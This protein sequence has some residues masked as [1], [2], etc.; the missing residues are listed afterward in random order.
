MG[1]NTV[2]YSGRAFA[3]DAHSAMRGT[4]VRGLIELITNCDDAYRDL[5]GKIRIEV[6]HRRRSVWTVVV[7]DR[8]T[9]MSASKLRTAI[10]GLGGRTSGFEAGEAVR[11]NLGRGAKD[12]A[13]FGPVRFES[14]CDGRYASMVLE[15]DGTYDDPIERK[16]L[17]SDRESLGIPKG[18]GTVVTVQVREQVQ[19]PRHGNLLSS[20]A[21]HYQLRDINA[22]PRR[23]LTL[24]DPTKNRA[25]TIRYSPPTLAVVLSVELAIEGYPEAAT[26]LT[27]YR[28]SECYEHAPSDTGRPQGILVKGERAIYENSLFRFENQP[29]SGWFSG[30]LDCPYID[31]LARDHDQRQQEGRELEARNPNPIITRG[32]DGLEPAHPFRRAVSKAVEQVLGPLIE[33]EERKAQHGEAKVSSKLRRSLDLLGQDLGKLIDGDLREIDEDGIPGDRDLG[34][35]F[36]LRI[37]PASVVMYMGESKTLS[38][39]ANRSLGSTNARV[40]VDPEGIAEYEGEA[41]VELT[42]HPRR[43]EYLIG[44]I[45]LAPV[46]EDEETCVT[47]KV[48]DQEAMAIVEVRPERIE[49]DPQP[50]EVFQFERHLY[51]LTH[52][53]RRSLLLQAPVDAV[54]RCGTRAKVAS[55]DAGIAVLGGGEIDLEFDEEAVA[56]VGTVEVD[57]RD[58]SARA[59]LVANLGDDTATCDALVAATGGGPTIAIKIAPKKAGK[60]RA[61]VSRSA[62]N[63]TI[64]IQ[65]EHPALKR[66]LGAAPDYPS[67][68][69]DS[70]RAMLAEIIAGEAARMV[71]EKKYQSGGDLDGPGFYSEHLSYLE[72]YLT[73]C[74]KMMLPDT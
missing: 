18:S 7:R 12:L 23:E 73:R 67:Q 55:T 5:K 28:N 47:V 31:F 4:I 27:V 35:E 71:L 56:F 57:P 45:R 52:G 10:G 13:A 62:D 22:D 20:L 72:K 65:G 61:L 48:G 51:R 21:T 14:I 3:Q 54:N 38:I 63:T 53:K 8:A 30:R 9:G 42:D 2:A 6:E 26:Q 11:G 49:P 17:S 68:T 15:E 40:E 46:I 60:F 32:R 41:V 19:C 39:V 70:A 64:E 36:G 50:P 25:D 24:V 1:K 16:A 44:Q 59:K 33:D 37:V 43:E 69:S 74:H 66:Y 58:L 29:Y 34:T